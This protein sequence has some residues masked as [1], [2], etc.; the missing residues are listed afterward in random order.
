M[1]VW[2]I[3]TW[4]AVALA[5]AVLAAMLISVARARVR[6]ELF[7]TLVPVAII[8]AA[9]TPAIRQASDDNFTANRHRER[10]IVALAELPRV[11][12]DVEARARP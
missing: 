7:W 3:T 9:A 4:V 12:H 6:W 5:F 8:V 1:N 2:A 10:T 11:A